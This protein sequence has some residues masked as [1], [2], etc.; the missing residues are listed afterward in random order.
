MAT[1]QLSPIAQVQNPAFGAL[2]LWR[3]VR[4]FQFEKPGE[5]PVLTLLFLLLPLTL[6]RP[7][8]EK[9]RSTNQSSGLAKFT[10]KLADER[11]RL[12][13]VHERAFALRSLTLDSIATG[14]ATKLLS[15]DYVNALVRANELT[16]PTTP[17]RLKNHLA[18]AEKLGR[19]FARLPPSLV[20]SLLKVEP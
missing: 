2:I 4:G 9:I 19:W 16:V 17:E 3:F 15:V 14:V 10:A 8:V 1:A 11:E 13:A 6:H 18:S 5:L 7:T 12:F 20:F